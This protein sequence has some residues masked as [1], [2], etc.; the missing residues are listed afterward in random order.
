VDN[1]TAHNSKQCAS[2]LTTS[3]LRRNSGAFGL[4]CATKRVNLLS[5]VFPAS[6]CDYFQNPPALACKTLCAI[7]RRTDIS[8]KMKNSNSKTRRMTRK[9]LVL[10]AVIFSLNIAGQS[11]DKKVM[12]SFVPKSKAYDIYYPKSFLLKEDNKGIVTISDPTS[13]LNIT[14]SSYSV[15]KGID[16]KKLIGQLN[17]FV[18]DYFK[19][20]IK[21]K[22]WNSYKTKFEILIESKFS[23]DKTNWVWYGI[24]DKQTLVT[25]SI[26]KDSS[27]EPEDLN[28]IRFMINNL[29]I[30]G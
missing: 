30:N 3:F 9:A 1:K 14:I 16:D 10:L 23:V 18:K 19:K 15:D 12:T 20:E 7:F 24:V 17:D 28:L 27:I 22:D 29:I 11:D 5:N 25:I 6:N 26:N 21:E 13:K 4:F 2:G 8:N